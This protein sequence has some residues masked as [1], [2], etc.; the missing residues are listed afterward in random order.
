M[1]Q[2][3]EAWQDSLDEEV[4]WRF[5]LSVP[6]GQR[7]DAAGVNVV[8]KGIRHDTDSGISDVAFAWP[9]ESSLKH[10][11]GDAFDLL[12]GT[13]VLFLGNSVTREL[14]ITLHE[15]IQRPRE[16]GPI[17]VVQV[18]EFDLPK[19]ENTIW[20]YH[21]VASAE[22]TAG[23]KV[24]SS[25]CRTKDSEPKFPYASFSKHVVNC[26]VAGRTASAEGVVMT[27][28]FTSTPAERAILKVLDAWS[29]E[30]RNDCAPELKPDI[31][32]LGLSHYIN[33]TAA[34]DFVSAVTRVALLRPEVAFIIVTAG[35]T[36]GADLATLERHEADVLAAA[37]GSPVIVAPYSVSTAKGMELH[38]LS[39]EVGSNYHF[40]D[41]GRYLAAHIV[42]NAINYTQLLR[43]PSPT[44]KPA[45][46][47]G[48]GRNHSGG[49]SRRTTL[50][51][52]T[53]HGTW[54]KQHK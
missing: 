3:R 54:L 4:T 9:R 30:S 25:K 43:E 47:P 51:P 31:A 13:H 49:R 22:V 50:S 45:H 21:G 33:G 7:A 19:T 28:A 27:Y 40:G 23:P 24:L 5:S 44:S 20:D 1:V 12:R 2:D 11:G 10:Y 17:D 8:V 39:H 46:P 26:C 38:A 14:V 36:R 37:R 29:N 32:V 41:A 48:L 35:H 16:Q 53:A 18:K 15:M 52:P 42:L 34:Q 6:A